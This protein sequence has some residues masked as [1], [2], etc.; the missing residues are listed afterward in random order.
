MITRSHVGLI[1]AA[2]PAAEKD[3]TSYTDELDSNVGAVVQSHH[4]MDV[5]NAG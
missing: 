3:K 1:G 5:V 2:E 4:K